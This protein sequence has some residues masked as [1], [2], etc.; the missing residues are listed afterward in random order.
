VLT[1]TVINASIENDGVILSTQENNR[2][3]AKAVIFAA[4]AR[5][6]PSLPRSLGLGVPPKVH[7]IY[8]SFPYDGKWDGADLTV[9]WNF[10]I[11]HRGYFWTA[12]C[13]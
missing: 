1:D 11:V 3:K 5:C 10:R 13:P 12:I 2:I 8:G 7:G 6:D 4:G 9:V